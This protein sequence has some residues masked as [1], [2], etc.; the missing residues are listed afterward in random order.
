[1]TLNYS[2]LIASVVRD[3]ESHLEKVFTNIENIS[4]R[5]NN[6]KVVFVESDS[7]D[8][9]LSI[10]EDIK[11][12]SNLDVQIISLGKLQDTFPSRTDRISHARNVYLDIAEKENYDYLLVLDSDEISTEEMNVDDVMSCF[13]Y[14][15]WDMMTSNQPS[16]YYDLW[17]LRHEKLMP[18]DCWKKVVERPSNISYNK[19]V[20]EY[21]NKAFFKLPKTEN[22]VKVNSAFGGAAFIKVKGI[23]GSR[24]VGHYENG[25]PICEWVPFC[26]RL[27][28]IFINPRFVN[29][30]VLSEHIKANMMVGK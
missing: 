23:N 24:H 17:A 6:V 11:T 21:V 22:P 30:S 10:L 13:D 16:G 28:N 14:E 12:N 18:Y 27:E 8:N 2:L 3:C 20:Y 5:F 19:A 7:S 25:I 9:T 26:D 1:M 4:K 29:S 15:D